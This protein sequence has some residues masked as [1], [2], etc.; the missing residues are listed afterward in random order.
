MSVSHS[1]IQAESSSFRDPSGFLF[2]QDGVLYRQV[3]QLYRQNYDQLMQSG[4]YEDLVRRRLL[5]PH[6][7]AA[8]QSPQPDA[9][10]KI[11]QPEPVAFI[12]YP[13][14]WSFGQ[15]KDAALTTLKIQKRS[16]ERGMSLKDA[17]AYN[18]QFHRGRPLL[19]DTLSFEAYPEGKPWV[20]Y[21]QFCQHFLAPLA[22]MAYCDVRL[23]QLLR[24]YIDG[25]PLDLAARLLPR[26][27]YLKLPLLMH[28]HLH[29][30]SQKRYAGKPTAGQ[31][32]D[33]EKPAAARQMT[34]SGL[35]GLIDSLESGI[36]SLH[37]SPG[38][39][40]WN[41]YYDVHN[42]SQAGL[43]AKEK[44]LA[45]FLDRIKPSNVWDLGAN[46]GKFS[47]IAS[48]RN[49]PTIAF[50][51]DPGAVEQNYRQC[52]AEKDTCMVPL[53][54]DLTNPS[55]A[56]GWQN[57]ERQSLLQRGPAEAVLALALV[58]HLAISNN[59]PLDRVAEF[60]AQAGRWLIIEFVPKSD[61][62]VKKLLASREDIF[63]E[64]TREGFEAAFSRYFQLQAAESIAESDRVLYLMERK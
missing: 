7:E 44:L 23:S 46:T 37:W 4:L 15:L 10:Y 60:F 32:A 16:L 49:I 41:D 52:V 24:V 50:D 18:I 64:Y 3:N 28:L 19:I 59:V 31:L 1:S 62:Q 17:S 38:G 20:A 54:S 6:Q 58:H 11:I 43:E 26:K 5:I 8:I 45:D 14:E 12:S 56:I 51:I 61:S 36:R 40:E 48:K 34:R 9:A 27:T 35:L 33:S 53:L 57:Q 22:L 2:R 42:Y 55:P 47:R 39:S 30:A 63:P 13:Y 21:R 25:A 29:A